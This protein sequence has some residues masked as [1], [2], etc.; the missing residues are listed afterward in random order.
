VHEPF[1]TR[2][3]FVTSRLLYVAGVPPTDWSTSMG[4]TFKYRSSDG[5]NSI[6]QFISYELLAAKASIDPSLSS[7]LVSENYNDAPSNELYS[8][9]YDSVGLPLNESYAQGA[10]KILAQGLAN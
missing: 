8:K 1:A 10:C 3:E 2:E 7:Y 5:A 4:A 9:Q 6:R